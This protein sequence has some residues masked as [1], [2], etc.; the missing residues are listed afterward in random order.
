[1]TKP[2]SLIWSSLANLLEMDCTRNE[3]SPGV[4]VVKVIDL[5]VAVPR[6]HGLGLFGLG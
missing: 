2:E 6:P 3:V 4:Y 1:M 5:T